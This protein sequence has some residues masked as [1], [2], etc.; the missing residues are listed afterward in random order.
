MAMRT[1]YL[2][3][4]RMPLNEPPV[5]VTDR[6]LGSQQN[7]IFLKVI[8]DKYSQN[9]LTRPLTSWDSLGVEG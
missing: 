4:F 5:S 1:Y 7:L 2:I 6:D 3:S 8:S 9:Y